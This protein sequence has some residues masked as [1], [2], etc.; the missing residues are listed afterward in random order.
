MSRQS[1]EEV[2]EILLAEIVVPRQRARRL[3]DVT[4]LVESI[5]Q[6]GLIE[7]IVVRRL[8]DG[9]LVL[10]CGAHRLEAHRQ[11]GRDRILARIIEVSDLEAELIELDE[12][13]E[14]TALTV[15][16]RGE[17][18]RRRK[19]VYEALHPETCQ[20]ARGGHAKAAAEAATEMISVAPAFTSDA[21]SRF[22]TSERS[23][24]E[25]IRIAT[26]L[27]PEAAKVLRGT[28]L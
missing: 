2:R 25:E 26:E 4:S 20:H 8:P 13:L 19:E 12:N 22:G 23:I 11:L 27:A 7:P 21:A 9:R 15:L 10:V 14:R 5:A 24:R 1:P 6:S 17:H 16:E 28:P 18:L 3:R